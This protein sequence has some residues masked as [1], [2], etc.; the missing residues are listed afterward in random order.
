V[1]IPAGYR[2]EAVTKKKEEKLTHGATSKQSLTGHSNDPTNSTPRRQS[3]K[4][5]VDFPGA[6]RQLAR[7]AGFVPRALLGASSDDEERT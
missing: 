3:L 4:Q 7:C 5:R 2:E 6:D 1:E